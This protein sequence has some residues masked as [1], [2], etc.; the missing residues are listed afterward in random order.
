MTD[1]QTDRQT[2]GLKNSVALTHPYHMGESCRKFG[3][4]LPR[5][6]GGDIVTDGWIETFTISPSLFFFFFLS[7]GITCAYYYLLT[8]LEIVG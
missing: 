1:G 3:Q 2:G 5:D 4:I 8:C 6:L 7:M